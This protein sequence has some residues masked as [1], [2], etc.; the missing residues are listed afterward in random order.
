MTILFPL[1]NQV[2]KLAA[3]HRLVVLQ[4]QAPQT[5]TVAKMV[6][7]PPMPFVDGIL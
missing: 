1:I 3:T 5:Q 2:T 7:V 6:E 4:R